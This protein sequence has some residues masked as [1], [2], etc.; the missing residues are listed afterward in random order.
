MFFDNGFGRSMD[1]LH[2]T[3]DV[4][5]LRRDVIANNIANADT[6]N[7]KRSAVNFETQLRDAL[8]NPREPRFAAALT[9]EKHIPFRQPMHY[10]D[11]RPTRFLDTQTTAKNNGNNVDIEQESMNL[12][13][14]ELMYTLLTNSISSQLSRVN[15]VL[16]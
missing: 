10:Q 1:I 6:P 8:E 14:N 12:L 16:R 15:L 13:N 7:F 4:N 5:L 11:V 3:M 9:N 2:R